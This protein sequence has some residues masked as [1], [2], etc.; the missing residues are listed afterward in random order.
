MEKLVIKMKNSH[1][2]SPVRM[3][4]LVK[5]VAAQGKN[6]DRE[7]LLYFKIRGTSSK[8]NKALKQMV[9]IQEMYGK[10]YERRMYHLIVSFPKDMH[11]KSV[12]IKCAD[13]ISDYIFKDY[14]V[15]YGIH[16]SKENWHIH[17]AIN[18]VSYRTGKK[19]HQSKKE[20][21]EFKDN[22]KDMIESICSE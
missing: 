16:M 6:K 14:Q 2:K 11:D 19:W 8:I 1:Y 15:A 18:A 9:C 22:L 10:D 4:N 5:Y 17:F 20:F 13:E 12:I 3:K 7:K 21:Q